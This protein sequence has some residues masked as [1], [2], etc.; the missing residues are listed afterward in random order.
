MRRSFWGA[1]IREARLRVEEE[2]ARQVRR[3]IDGHH[4]LLALP[5]PRQVE[6]QRKLESTVVES[7]TG[8]ESWS[9]M[10][11]GPDELGS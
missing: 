8:V 10:V 7:R 6:G 1:K 2:L 5:V 9:G 11:V 3:S 4:G